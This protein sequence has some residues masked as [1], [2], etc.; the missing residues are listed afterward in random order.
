MELNELINALLDARRVRHGLHTDVVIQAE[1]A[2]EDGGGVQ[3][4]PVRLVRLEDVAAS[5][6]ARSCPLGARVVLETETA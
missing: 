1:S 3:R 2:R 5:G 4:G 6:P